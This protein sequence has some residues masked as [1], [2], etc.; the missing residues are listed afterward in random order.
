MPI[1]TRRSQSQYFRRTAG[2][3]QSLNADRKKRHSN[4]AAVHP[5]RSAID[6]HDLTRI[7]S[8]YQNGATRTSTLEPCG[9]AEPYAHCPDVHYVTMTSLPEVKYEYVN[10]SDGGCG[11][12]PLCPVPPSSPPPLMYYCRPPVARQRRIPAGNPAREREVLKRQQRLQVLSTVSVDYSLNTGNSCVLY[13]VCLY[14][15]NF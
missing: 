11:S 15:C 12:T 7:S 1:L 4:N 13:I 9:R 10:G 6:S 14:P 2:S 8:L 3:V 5:V